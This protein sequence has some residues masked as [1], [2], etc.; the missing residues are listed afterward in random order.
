MKIFIFIILVF[1][2]FTKRTTA[3]S[4]VVILPPYG[5]AWWNCTINIAAVAN[6]SF[7]I[8]IADDLAPI[9]PGFGSYHEGNSSIDRIQGIGFTLHSSASSSKVQMTFTASNNIQVYNSIFYCGTNLVA[10]THCDSPFMGLPLQNQ[11][12]QEW[13]LYL[14]NPFNN[15]QKAYVSIFPNRTSTNA[16]NID[17]SV[18]G[19]A[20][21]TNNEHLLLILL[22]LFQMLWEYFC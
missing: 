7:S 17:K 15:S 13:C 20:E 14:S 3:Q 22:I 2:I 11:T 16:T 18:S 4:G 10:V 5:G 6:Q 8:K 21:N 19:N 12:D 9:T 1:Q